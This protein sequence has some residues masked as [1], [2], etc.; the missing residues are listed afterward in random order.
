MNIVLFLQPEPVPGRKKAFLHP[1]QA[2]LFLPDADEAA[3]AAA[4]NLK[5][6][7]PDR[8]RITAVAAGPSSCIKILR[9]ALGAGADSAV[10]INLPE[11]CS[12]PET[13]P[14]FIQ[15][16]L[17]L[18]PDVI[19]AG[20]GNQLALHL[21]KALPS[22]EIH[23]TE[24][25]SFPKRYAD[26]Q[27][28]E[29]AGK[30]EILSA[31]PVSAV[32]PSV[33]EDREI[34]RKRILIKG[35]AEE[36]ADVL[37]RALKDI[38]IEKILP[39][40]PENRKAL[41]EKAGVIFHSADPEAADLSVAEI[42]V[43]GGRG[44]GSKE[45][46][47]SSAAALARILGGE[48]AGTRAAVDAGWIPPSRQVGLSG[49]TVEPEIY[50]ALGICGAQQH[51]AGMNRARTVVAFNSDPAAPFFETADYCVAGDLNETVPA[52]IKKL[53]SEKIS[54]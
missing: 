14:V 54:E 11:I 34:I 35:T 51:T 36:T 17:D 40:C 6:Q 21:K 33:S 19:F 50:F 4:M 23:C 25:G 2:A 13:V 28:L 1:E 29:D 18:Q 42:I 47:K 7:D 41:Y 22:A 15:A 52:F 20:S 24:A 5:D 8:N 44:C 43:S 3:L 39:C 16:A 48:Y 53:V 10:R 49:K 45:N 31:E 46:F 30:K 27:G 12:G 9:M 37:Y 26:V 32:Q 38:L